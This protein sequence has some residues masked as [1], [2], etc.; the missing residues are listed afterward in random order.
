MKASVMYVVKS[1]QLLSHEIMVILNLKDMK[2]ETKTIEKLIDKYEYAL[3]QV[4]P[5]TP[6]QTLYA[7][8]VLADM[9]SE[10]INIATNELQKVVYK[11]IVKE[12]KKQ[13]INVE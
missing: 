2:M 6:E 3:R 1:N 9:L 13:G 12:L 8:K 11:S 7:D 4:I 10:T 5:M